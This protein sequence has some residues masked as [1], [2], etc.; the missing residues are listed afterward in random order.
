M[1]ASGACS[2]CLPESGFNARAMQMM[3]VI[4]QL[5]ELPARPEDG[6]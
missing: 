6:V 3:G 4:A 2:P 5:A 1:N